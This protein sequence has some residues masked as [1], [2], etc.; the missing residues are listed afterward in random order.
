VTDDRTR[1]TA[2]HYSSRAAL[3]DRQRAP[4]LR[5]MSARLL[6]ALPLA[7]ARVVLDLGTG[8]GG[9]LPVLRAAA[10]GAQLVGVDAAEGMLAVAARHEHG[11]RLV[12]GDV[13]AL[14]LADGCADTAVFSFVLHRVAEPVRALGE[15]RR[16]LRPDGR[17]GV[18]SWGRGLGGAE[19]A[20]I[21]GE[22]LARAGAP[23]APRQPIEHHDM[24][25][26][27]ERMA[28]LLR[29]A[30]LEPERCWEERFERPRGVEELMADADLGADRLAGVAEAARD[31]CLRRVRERLAALDPDEL[32]YRS[33]AVYG[34][35]QRT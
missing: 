13:Q 24:L 17:V 14:P 1:R 11:A 34:V 8:T 7:A 22:E 23:P 33:Q 9:L 32:A 19:A 5:A 26:T 18:V 4:E 15:A 2:A 31:E 3:F 21:V 10:P 25:D 6:P 20:A 29:A 16:C 27:P 35:G 28:A 30:G 12:L